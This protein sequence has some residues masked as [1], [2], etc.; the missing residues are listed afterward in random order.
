MSTRAP[1]TTG[2]DL[3]SPLVL[4]V[5]RAF[6]LPVSTACTTPFRSPT[7][8]SPFATAGDDSPIPSPSTAYVQSFFPLERSIATRPAPLAPTKTAP[9]AIAAE[10]SIDSP[11]STVHLTLSA[12][13]SVAS[14]V[15]VSPAVPRN[16]VQPPPGGAGTANRKDATTKARIWR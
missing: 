6:P 2:D 10:D 3:I 13:G 14:V 1:E 8:T 4:Y 12:S 11:A 5:Q 9:S 16:C 15:P 7:N